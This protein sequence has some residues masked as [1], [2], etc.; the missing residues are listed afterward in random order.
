MLDAEDEILKQ[1]YRKAYKETLSRFAVKNRVT[2]MELD[3]KLCTGKINADEYLEAIRQSWKD[4]IGFST[5][6]E[7]MEQIYNIKTLFQ[8]VCEFGNLNESLIGG[9]MRR[10]LNSLN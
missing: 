1:K 2:V 10:I 6:K 9:E 8:S 7:K 3:M 5:S 4:V